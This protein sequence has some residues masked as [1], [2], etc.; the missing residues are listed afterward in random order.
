MKIWTQ[1]LP[2]ITPCALWSTSPWQH[3]QIYAHRL[4]SFWWR[5]HNL[6][7]KVLPY[8]ISTR[9]LP[10]VPDR[11]FN[12][13]YRYGM[14]VKTCRPNTASTLITNST[15]NLSQRW[16]SPRN[17]N[18]SSFAWQWSF[19][20][21][22]NSFAEATTFMSCTLNNVLCGRCSHKFARIIIQL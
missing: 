12:S 14:V 8:S 21:G 6:R 2:P 22:I 3:H 18:Q 16:N 13:A 5:R 10:Q 15:W 1:N 9:S 7:I 19:N 17:P 20:L 11:V 4:P